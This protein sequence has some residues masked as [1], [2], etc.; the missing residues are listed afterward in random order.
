MALPPA[1]N[2]KNECKKFMNTFKMM[3]WKVVPRSLHLR[4]VLNAGAR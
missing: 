2:E 1:T 3:L 4:F